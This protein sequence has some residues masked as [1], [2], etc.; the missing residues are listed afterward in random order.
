MQKNK[1][2]KMNP[3]PKVHFDPDF[4]LLGRGGNS[5]AWLTLQNHV[6]RI[7]SYSPGVDLVNRIQTELARSSPFVP[8]VYGSSVMTFKELPTKY[9]DSFKEC[10]EKEFRDDSKLAIMDMEYG[11]AKIE[12]NDV[13]AVT[14]CLLWFMYNA[15]KDYGFQHRDIKPT[16]IVYKTTTTQRM[17]FRLGQ[18][19]FVIPN[20]RIKPMLIDFD[21]SEIRVD[22]YTASF[23]R[24]KEYIDGTY[25]F[26]PPE[27]LVHRASHVQ[28]IGCRDIWSIALSML[29]IRLNR[30]IYNPK[31]EGLNAE[32][33][34]AMY[35]G[36]VSEG[37]VLYIFPDVFCF[38]KVLHKGDPPDKLY[39]D[40]LWKDNVILNKIMVEKTPRYQNL[41]GRLTTEERGFY[42]RALAWKP[43]DRLYDGKMANYFTLPYFKEFQNGITEDESYQQSVPRNVWEG[44]TKSVVIGALASTICFS[45]GEKQATHFD[46]GDLKC[47]ECCV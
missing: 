12:P 18:Q 7:S 38:L 1:K 28:E 22:G 16:N 23:R 24:E 2:E 10:M 15:I 45:C 30:N 11:D 27:Y 36:K 34:K 41:I 32:Y 44:P 25:V 14:F 35:N 31:R 46:S 6:I 43:T 9:R 17:E 42:R 20:L 4:K 26:L 21:T 39:N 3:P 5:C 33:E 13:P 47:E 19:K 40:W 29:H 8:K 37:S